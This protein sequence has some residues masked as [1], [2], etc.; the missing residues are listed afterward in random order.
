MELEQVARVGDEMVEALAEA[1]DICQLGPRRRVHLSVDRSIK[2]ETRTVSSD[3]RVAERARSCLSTYLESDQGLWP[4]RPVLIG[5]EVAVSLVPLRV[6]FLDAL[7]HLKAIGH[8]E[9]DGR[10]EL[11]E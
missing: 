2:Q 11:S 9:S 6:R 1:R 3:D 4:L 8:S 5:S 7:E 10:D